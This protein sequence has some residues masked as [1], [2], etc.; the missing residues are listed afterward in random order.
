MAPRALI[1]IHFAKDMVQQDISAARR[2]GAGI[3]ADDSVKTKCSLYRFAFEPAVEEAARR[4]GEQ[5]QHITLL[6]QVKLHQPASLHG[7]IDEGL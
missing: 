3:I 4:F 7:G 1:A 6:R 5:F 2:V